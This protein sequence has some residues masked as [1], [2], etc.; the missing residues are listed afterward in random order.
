MADREPRRARGLLEEALVLRGPGIESANEVT[1]ATLI[2]ARMGDWP[3]TLQLA[4]RTIR[5]LRW[6]GQRSFLG[7]ILNVVARAFAHTDSETAA[8][9]Q[10]A[11]RHTWPSNSPP[12][13]PQLRLTPVSPRQPLRPSDHR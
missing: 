13:D 11:A 3:L 2:A 9:L 5:H 10:G 7:G 6:T 12:P 4:D 1:Q 8:R